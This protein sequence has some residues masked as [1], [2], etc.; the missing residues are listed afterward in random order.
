MALN[1]VFFLE[2]QSNQALADQTRPTLRLG[3]LG[4][5]LGRG[6][7]SGCYTLRHTES[8]R[9]DQFFS[10]A[11]HVPTAVG[12]HLVSV[13]HNTVAQGLTVFD[14]VVA[15]QTS[16]AFP[17][18]I[19]SSSVAFASSGFVAMWHF[20]V[21]SLSAWLKR[22][23]LSIACLFMGF[24]AAVAWVGV[25][26]NWISM[27]TLIALSNIG[28]SGFGDVVVTVKQGRAAMGLQGTLVLL[29][30]ILWGCLLVRLVGIRHA[31]QE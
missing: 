25:M 2:F 24:A 30:T 20:Y 7:D 1:T 12:T 11:Y 3:Y 31:E 29:L 10:N 5:C 22:R 18:L 8:Y 21:T 4:Y 27:G 26:Q 14:F 15:I 23:F 17:Y 9:L 13:P 19:I 6:D 28:F 16:V